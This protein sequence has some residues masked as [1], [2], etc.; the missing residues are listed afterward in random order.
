MISYVEIMESLFKELFK[1]IPENYLVSDSFCS[2]IHNS[3]FYFQWKLLYDY[4]TSS[5]IFG[6]KSNKD[7][8]YSAF[9]ML[10][11]QSYK[12]GVNSLYEVILL[13]VSGY[14]EDYNVKIEISR[15]KDCLFKLGIRSCSELDQYTGTLVNLSLSENIIKDSQKLLILKEKLEKSILEQNYNYC[16]TLCYSMLEGIFKG[17]CNYFQL[18]CNDRDEITKL[19]SVVKSDIKNRFQ[20]NI[21]SHSSL[22]NQISTTANFAKIIRDHYSD[23]HF[24]GDS[25]KL[26]SSFLKDLTI[27]VCN[28]I[29]GIVLSH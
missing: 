4:D 13:V 19:A 9:V 1:N 26:A 20:D 24:D 16:S 22:Y 21:I 2:R 27:S 5:F 25:D 29:T 18:N 8:A 28:F 3:D 12:N 11:K 6:Y 17:Y 23:S 15:I 10:C 7:K 14:C